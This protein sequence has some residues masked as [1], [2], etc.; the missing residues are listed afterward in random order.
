MAREK[1]EG[2]AT[3]IT[4][5]GIELDS[6]RLQLRLPLV[7]LEKLRELVAMWRQ[8]KACTKKEPQSLAGHLSHACKVVRPGRRFLRGLFGL[9]SQFRRRDHMIRLNSVFRAD[10]EWWHVF[11]SSWNGVSMM[12]EGCERDQVVEMCG[13]VGHFGGQMVSSVM[14]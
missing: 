11:A 3:V 8:R 10:L 4:L 14:A 12:Q 2:P 5:L 6:V 1:T 13:V 9:I 7:K